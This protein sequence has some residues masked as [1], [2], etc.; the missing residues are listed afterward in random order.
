MKY[1]FFFVLV[2]PFLFPLVHVFAEIDGVQV[3]LGVIGCNTNNMCE[4]AIGENALNCPADCSSGV[5]IIRSGGGNAGPLNLLDTTIKKIPLL[6]QYND[7]I[8]VPNVHNL[9]L[10]D[11]KKGI[12]VN[13]SNPILKN[14]DYIRVVRTSNGYSTNPFEGRVV[15]EGN[16][17]YFF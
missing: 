3:N 16:K 6:Q 2:T 13:W 15:Y 11:T 17:N 12:L 5:P 9:S 8:A 14:I 10:Q 1:L 4:S 7:I